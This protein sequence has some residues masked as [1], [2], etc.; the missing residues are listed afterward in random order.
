MD[1]KDFCLLSFFSI[2]TIFYCI[3]AD[4]CL[5]TQVLSPGV[6]L[7]KGLADEALTDIFLLVVLTMFW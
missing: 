2:I 5:E 4:C 7:S 6:G 1:D 3:E